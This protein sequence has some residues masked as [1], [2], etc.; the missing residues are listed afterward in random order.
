[1]KKIVTVFLV[2]LMTIGMAA[3]AFASPSPSPNT[4]NDPFVEDPDGK[5]VDVIISKTDIIPETPDG[6]TPIWIKKI[7]TNEDNPKYPLTVT[8]PVDGVKEGS[9]VIVKIYVDGEWKQVKAVV[10]NGTVTITLDQLGTIAIFLKS[11]S[12]VSP[13]TGETPITAGLSAI[14]AVAVIGIYLTSRKKKA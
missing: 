6:Y 4:N 8:I 3:T 5:K 9:E 11:D 13:K 2:L 14:A 7:T 12:R 10:G 1:M